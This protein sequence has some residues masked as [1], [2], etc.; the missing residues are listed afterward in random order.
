MIGK[1]FGKLTVIR[2]TGERYHK[3]IIYE[4]LC[5]CGNTKN[6]PSL[7]LGNGGTKSCGCLKAKEG[8]RKPFVRNEVKIRKV[9]LDKKGLK[10]HRLT[11]IDFKKEPRTPVRVVLQCDCGNI[12]TK[13]AKDFLKGKIKSCGCI[14][15]EKWDIARKRKEEKKSIIKDTTFKPTKDLTGLQ[16][17]K[18]S[19]LYLCGARVTK[20]RSKN[21]LWYCRCKCGKELIKTTQALLSDADICG[22]DL[23][24][25]RAKRGR[26]NSLKRIKS[27][28]RY[29]QTEWSPR[30]DIDHKNRRFV[31]SSK[32]RMEEKHANGCLICGHQGDE[33][34][35]I[36]AHHLKPHALFPKL[37][38]LTINLIPLCKNCHD[39]LHKEL[40][41]E[42]TSIP[43]QMEFIDKQRHLFGVKYHFKGVI[44]I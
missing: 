1:R 23:Y 36:C 31:I 20:A 19:V 5:D 40:G 9:T 24:A 33:S 4:C 8:G 25:S 28:T 2:D 18:I 11:I 29:L 27:I 3:H 15:K 38:Y 30:D 44:N 41:W 22:C 13:S 21:A 26:E 10:I 43:Q 12:I 14:T 17:G 7:R 35:Y 6:V 34:N 39:N 42:N 16:I 37:R 32:R